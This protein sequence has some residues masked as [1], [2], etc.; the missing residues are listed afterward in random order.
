MNSSNSNTLFSLSI[1]QHRDMLCKIHMAHVPLLAEI[2]PIAVSENDALEFRRVGDQ[3]CEFENWRPRMTAASEILQKFFAYSDGAV[4]VYKASEVAPGKCVFSHAMPGISVTC[5]AV[6]EVP[7]SELLVVGHEKGIVCVKIESPGEIARIDVDGGVREVAVA[8]DEPCVYFLSGTRLMKWRVEEAAASQ[9]DE[10]VQ[11][12]CSADK[13]VLYVKQDNLMRY[14]GS[15][16][17]VSG[18]CENTIAVGRVCD[19]F[20]VT[21]SVSRDGKDVVAVACDLETKQAVARLVKGV[22]TGAEGEKVVMGSCCHSNAILIGSDKNSDVQLLWLRS[23]DGFEQLQLEDCRRFCCSPNLKQGRLHLPVNFTLVA[24]ASSHLSVIVEY[25]GSVCEILQLVS[26]KA[27]VY[28]PA[29]QVVRRVGHTKQEDL[30]SKPAKENQRSQ[31][32]E[33]EECAK[34]EYDS[35]IDEELEKARLPNI[36]I[37]KD[38]LGLPFWDKDDDSFSSYSCYSDDEDHI[39]GPA[40]LLV[41]DSDKYEC[42]LKDTPIPCALLVRGVKGYESVT[43]GITAGQLSSIEMN[44][45]RAYVRMSYYSI[46]ASSLNEGPYPRRWVLEGKSD[47]TNGWVVIDQRENCQDFQTDFQ[48][49]V[50]KVQRVVDAQVIRL[51]GRNL[52]MKK[53][54]PLGLR[55]PGPA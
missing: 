9:V 14:D 53:F 49:V 38:G 50:F 31:E 43:Q 41:K 11:R 16:V 46:E 44:F 2:A 37:T 23:L 19:H 27:D 18:L 29:K 1:R 54:T 34:L 3:T 26:Q 17:C 33:N 4:C 51:R 36:T 47:I 55:F 25:E 48:T 24:D 22:L 39:P 13:G 12:L 42:L 21:L 7:R 15:V 32:E 45:N 5:L 30:L 35:S 28:E 10:N 52:A 40:P 20:V 8:G 6:C